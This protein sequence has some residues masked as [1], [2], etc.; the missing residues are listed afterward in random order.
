MT[1]PA[2][3]SIKEGA[4]EL[5]VGRTKTYEL[6]DDGELETVKIGRRHL[7]V[8]ASIGRLVARLRSH[9]ATSW[10]E[11]VREIVEADEADEE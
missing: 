1:T 10:D 2:L 9:P 5:G 7:I 4:A 11:A 6:I 8:Y 3:V